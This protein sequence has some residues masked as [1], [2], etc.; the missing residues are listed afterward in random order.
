MRNITHVLQSKLETNGN[1]VSIQVLSLAVF[2]VLVQKQGLKLAI[3]GSL[4]RME[5]DFSATYSIHR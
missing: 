4:F 5:M 2:P 1:F 3:N